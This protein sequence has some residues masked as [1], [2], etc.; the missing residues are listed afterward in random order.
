MNVLIGHAIVWPVLLPLTAAAVCMLCWRLPRVQ[1]VVHLLA[2]TL[3]LAAAWLLLVQVQRHGVVATTFGGWAP[4]FGISFVADRFGAAMV[5][6]TA[7]LALAAGI[8]GL[9]STHQR[10]V[11]NGVFPLLLAMLAAVNGAFLTGDIFNLY[12]WFEIMLIAAL[13]LLVLDQGRAQLD[14]A[15]KYAVLN[16]LSTLLFLLAIA[17]LYGVTGTLNMADLAQV[18]PATPMRAALAVSAALFLVGFAIK[19]GCFPMF[20]WLPASYHTLPVAVL[21]LFAGLLT[22]VGVFACYRV[23]TLLLENGP[24]LRDVMAWMAAGTMLF[25]VFG[26]AVQWDVRRILS[27][28][29]ISQI[30]YI[31]LGLALGSAAG[32]AGGIFYILHHIIVKANLFLIAGAMYRASGTY[33]LRRM[34]GLA[35]SQPLLALLFAIPALS[36]AGIPPLSGFW[37]KFLVIDATLRAGGG[38]LAAVALFVGL[39]TIFSMSKIW[40]EAFWKRAPVLRTRPR[41]LP[42]SMMVPIAALATITVWIGM[43]PQ[44]LVAYSTL[45]AQSLEDVSPYIQA[46]F[47]ARAHGQE[48]GR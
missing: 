46:T 20:F 9:A 8:F 13:G 48:A 38:W 26:A 36:L 18:L 29:I 16:L 42:L 40:I 30:G 41:R 43:A 3:L 1:Q 6:I 5:V 27:F 47:G 19:A 33:D 15:M 44:T 39:L 12:V 21:A 2:L 25:G 31:L 24:A 4:P 34:G 32:L 10:H 37:A 7:V 28:H 22:K 14:G 11:R 45:A 17:L 23:F 35:R